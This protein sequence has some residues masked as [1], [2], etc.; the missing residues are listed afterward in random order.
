MDQQAEKWVVS[1]LDGRGQRAGHQSHFSEARAAEI[2][3]GMMRRGQRGVEIEYQQLVDGIWKPVRVGRLQPDRPM[4]SGCRHW[5]QQ[6]AN[7]AAIGVVMGEC[8]HSPPGLGALAIPAGNGMMNIQFMSAYPPRKPD[9]VTCGQ[10]DPR[11]EGPAPAAPV[12]Q[13]PAEEEA[14]EHVSPGGI[15]IP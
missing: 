11:P 5:F 10:Y 12:E 3:S 9:D 1:Y 8:R 15:L 13:P 7:P 6:A 2:A 14:N 4:C